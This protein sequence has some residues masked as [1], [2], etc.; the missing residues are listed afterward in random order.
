MIITNRQLCLICAAA[1]YGIIQAVFLAT[2]FERRDT[3]GGPALVLSLFGWTM[4]SIVY[5][6]NPA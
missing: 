1:A 3:A 5:I 6:F 4:L 2:E